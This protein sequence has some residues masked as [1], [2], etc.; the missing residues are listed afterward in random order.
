VGAICAYEHGRD[1]PVPYL[2]LGSSAMSGPLAA[3]TG[4]A[5][6]TNQI[7]TLLSPQS[8]YPDPGSYTPAPGFVPTAS[9]EGFVKQ[10]LDASANRF[11]ATR[12]QAGSNAKQVDAFVKSLDR[13]GLL[14]D[15][16]SKNGGFGKQAY[17]PDIGVQIDVGTAA[18][19]Q[20]LSF[21]VMMETQ[22]WDTHTNNAKQGSLADSLYSGL[23]TLGQ[24]LEDLK[25]LDN[26]VVLVISEMGRTPKLNAAAGKDHWP[27]TSALVFGAGVAGG[28]VLG[29]TDN[30]LGAQSLDLAT[31][32]VDS[33]NGVQLQT[34]NLVAGVLELA[35]VDPSGYLPGVEPFHAIHS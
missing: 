18:L 8:A 35:G 20:S 11:A 23:M 5:G 24:K 13:V 29:A 1:M 19:E 28:R 12:A 10:F 22:S 6:T 4:R 34:G 2:V 17:T 7:S 16:A 21:A 15:F 32:Q 25:L 9:D 30:Q 14:R 26:T 27:V 33:Q 31:G 3:I